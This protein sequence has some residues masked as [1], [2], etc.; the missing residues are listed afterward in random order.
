METE[1]AQQA[2]QTACRVPHLVCC[3]QLQQLLV[4]EAATDHQLPAQPD[5]VHVVVGV[6]Q[7]EEL[8]EAVAQLQRLHHGHVAA[9]HLQ[10]AAQ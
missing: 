3:C 8:E 5:V 4:A 1:T 10:D 7:R 2:Q 9:V 6:L